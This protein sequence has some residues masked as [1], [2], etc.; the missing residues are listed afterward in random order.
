[1]CA[2]QRFWPWD[3][4]R[5]QTDNCSRKS[6]GTWEKGWLGKTY[7]DTPAPLK[8]LVQSHHDKNLLIPFRRRAYEVDAMVRELLSRIDGVPG[9][10]WGGHIPA[11]PAIKRARMSP[12]RTLHIIHD[13]GSVATG[14]AHEMA[15]TLVRLSPH[16]VV[17]ADSEAAASY[18]L[19]LL[20]KDVLT[21]GSRSFT[22]LVRVVRTKDFSELAFVYLESGPDA[23]DWGSV[24]KIQIE[25]T[26][27]KSKVQNAIYG[28][29]AYKYRPAE[30]LFFEHSAMALDILE[31]LDHSDNA[32]EDLPT[33]A[34]SKGPS[35][36]AGEVCGDD[37]SK[38]SESHQRDSS[39]GPTY[40]WAA[41]LIGQ[42][43]QVAPL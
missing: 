37:G 3:L 41:K 1:M 36:S 14:M 10:V 32:N 17:A 39:C 28:H 20:T 29:E 13:A 7:D 22:D 31:R 2:L 25:D 30:P 35:N 19:I 40:S 23:W 12:S 15:N 4:Q 33:D 6:D 26:E 9:V 21:H 43:S 38:L 11:N 8:E 16:C 18:A 24:S 27:L 5:W 34:A 42:S